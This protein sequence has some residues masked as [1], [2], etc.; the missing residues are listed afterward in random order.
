MPN[1]FQKMV[2]L[3]QGYTLRKNSPVRGRPKTINDI[4]RTKVDEVIHDTKLN[5]GMRSSTQSRG[6]RHYKRKN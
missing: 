6:A 3:L 2:A 5:D 1:D 4:D